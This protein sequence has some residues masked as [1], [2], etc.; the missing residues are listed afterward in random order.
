MTKDQTIKIHLVALAEY[1]QCE[2]SDAQVK[3]YA[4]ELDMDVDQLALAIALLK[5]DPDVWPGKFPL[6]GKIKS[7]L[8]TDAEDMANTMVMNV[9]KAAD[10]GTHNAYSTLTEDEKEII[11]VY[12]WAN[13]ANMMSGQRPNYISNMRSI[14][15][16]IITNKKKKYPALELKV[17]TP[18]IE[19]EETWGTP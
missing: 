11:K 6:P 4:K 2:L 15:K 7:Y 8:T 17:D 19:G 12:G 3:M 13:L 16:T 14:A 18:L 5:Q 1:L 10:A 9:L